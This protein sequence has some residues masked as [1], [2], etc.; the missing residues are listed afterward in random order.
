MACGCWR[1]VCT[2]RTTRRS[3]SLLTHPAWRTRHLT[4]IGTQPRA[5]RGPCWRWP[6]YSTQVEKAGGP[7]SGSVSLAGQNK[8]FH[9]GGDRRAFTCEFPAR[10][11]LGAGKEKLALTNADGK[12]TLYVQTTGGIPSARRRGC[13]CCAQPPARAAI[14]SSARTRKYSMTARSPIRLQGRS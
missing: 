8:T 2:R 5:T 6:T 7:A 1:G 3:K 4:V 9:L 13:E 11:L 10:R 14:S 12:R